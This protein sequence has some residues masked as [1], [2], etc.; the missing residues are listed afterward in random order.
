[1]QSIPQAGRI[2]ISRRRWTYISASR[3]VGHPQGPKPSPGAAQRPNPP[4]WYLRQKTFALRS[5]EFVVQRSPDLLQDENEIA[6]YNLVLQTCRSPFQQIIN[7]AGAS[8]EVL[9]EKVLEHEDSFVGVDATDL[10]MKNLIEAGI[11]DPLKVV[12]CALANA[13]SV[14]G[15]MLTTEVIVRKPEKPEPATAMPGM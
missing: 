4:I 3:L 1:M 14:A 6:G 10:T 5:E 7:N 9:V 13:V 15:T 2:A 12:R 8:A 11:I